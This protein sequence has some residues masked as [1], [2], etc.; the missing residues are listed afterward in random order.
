MWGIRYADNGN[1]VFM[2]EYLVVD[3]ALTVEIE[4]VAL[5]F[6]VRDLFDEDYAVWSDPYYTRQIQLGTPRYMKLGLA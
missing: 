6:R 2:K 5:T 3:T 4:G 1:S